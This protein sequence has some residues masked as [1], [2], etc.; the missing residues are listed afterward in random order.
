LPR[1]GLRER[2]TG[3]EQARRGDN[4]SARLGDTAHA[5]QLLCVYARGRAGVALQATVVVA[6]KVRPVDQVTEAVG[7]DSEEQGNIDLAGR[8]PRKVTQ[9]YLLYIADQVPRCVR[10]EKWGALPAARGERPSQWPARLAVGLGLRGTALPPFDGFTPLR[11]WIPRSP[12]SGRGLGQPQTSTT[13]GIF[14]RWRGYTLVTKLFTTG[15][16]RG[17]EPAQYAGRTRGRAS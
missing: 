5:G 15:S 13:T 12:P 7:A 16:L 8:P 10:R 3:R 6:G 4:A 2:D 1:E 17:V 9:T 11:R 14:Q